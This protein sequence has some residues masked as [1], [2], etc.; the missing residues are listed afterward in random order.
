METGAIRK[1]R[2][3]EMLPGVEYQ[4]EEDLIRRVGDIA[5]TIFHPVGTCKMGSDPMAVVD[6]HLRVH[7]LIEIARGRCLDHAGDRFRQYQ[8]TCHHDRREGGGEHFGG[9]L[10]RAIVDG[11]W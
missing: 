3:Q 9:S 4:S 6:P 10:G 5:T 8:F 7:G 11:H 1:Y 2:P